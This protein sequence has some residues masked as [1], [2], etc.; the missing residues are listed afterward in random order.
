MIQDVII[1]TGASHM[2]IDTEYLEVMDIPLLDNDELGKAI[3]YGGTISYSLRKNLDE[4]RCGDLIKNNIKIDFG[5]IDPKNRISGLIGLD[6]LVS[7]GSVIDLVDLN[8]YKK[9]K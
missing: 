6:F 1:D 3:G 7:A 9:E 5:V 8:I 4:I 2:V